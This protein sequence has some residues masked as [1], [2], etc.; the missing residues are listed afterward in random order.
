LFVEETFSVMETRVVLRFGD[1]NE[2][3]RESICGL[4]E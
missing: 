1:M 3:M 2:E 4:T